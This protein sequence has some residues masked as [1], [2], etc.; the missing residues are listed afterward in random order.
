MEWRR[1]DFV[2]SDDRSRLDRGAVRR[3]IA[4]ESYWAA[5]IRK[6]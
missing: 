1:G 2:V 5:G 4:D 3:F 6:A